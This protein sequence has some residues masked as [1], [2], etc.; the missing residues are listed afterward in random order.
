MNCLR[1]ASNPAVAACSHCGVGMCADCVNAAATRDAKPVCSGCAP[2]LIKESIMEHSRVRIKSAVCLV[3][4]GLLMGLGIVTAG[5]ALVKGGGGAVSNAV[6]NIVICFGIAGLPNAWAG[7]R[8]SES[9][10]AV[11]R[12]LLSSGNGGG[13]LIGLIIKLCFGFIFGTIIAPFN[14]YRFYRS[15]SNSGREIAECQR[16]LA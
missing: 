16:L 15:F 10:R 12:A 4:T 7:M 2:A 11:D 8:G 3:L 1:H 9:D 6:F 5:A 13:V 14:A